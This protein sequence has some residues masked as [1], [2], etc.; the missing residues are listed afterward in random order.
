[1]AIALRP[2]SEGCIVALATAVATF[3]PFRFPRLK[4]LC[5]AA[6]LLAL[7]P[8][9][10]APTLQAGPGQLLDDLPHAVHAAV[11]VAA[12]QLEQA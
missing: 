1:M 10:G 11:D 3:L 8:H 12:G 2:F 4:R 7:H 6:E 9:L 5:L